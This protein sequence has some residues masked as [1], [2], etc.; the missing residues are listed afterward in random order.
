MPSPR[1][2]IFDFDGT[3]ADSREVVLAQYNRIAPRLRVRP[4]QRSELE[5]LQRLPPN[6]ALRAYGVAWWKLPLLVFAVR[7]ALREEV[8]RIEL[9]QGVREVLDEL[10]AEGARCSVLSTNA[11]DNIERF[12]AHHRLPRFSAIRG[13]VSMFGKARALDRFV[14]EQGI[15]RERAVYV[16]DEVRDVEAA[17]SVGVRCIAVTWGFS[18]RDALASK[19][20]WRLV[21]TARELADV[22]RDS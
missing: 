2:V 20:P 12:A 13:G 16:G 15:E 8:L 6:E 17:H 21:D 4:V 9:C 11:T 7:R 19:E 22:I 18:H 3:L 5:Q 14:R 1:A 10:R